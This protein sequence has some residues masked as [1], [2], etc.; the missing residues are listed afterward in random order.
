MSERKKPIRESK[1]KETK[2]ERA[3]LN[4]EDFD[5]KSSR[6]INNIVEVIDQICP[7]KD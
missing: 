1:A 6:R 5:I 3:R 4:F 7:K 2:Q